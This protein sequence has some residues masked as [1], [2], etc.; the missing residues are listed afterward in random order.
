MTEHWKF[1]LWSDIVTVEMWPQYLIITEI[2][3]TSRKRQLSAYFHSEKEYA[4]SQKFKKGNGLLPYKVN[5]HPSPSYW[6]EGQVAPCWKHYGK[7]S[8]ISI[9]AK[10]R[11][12]TA[13]TFTYYIVVLWFVGLLPLLVDSEQLFHSLTTCCLFRGRQALAQSGSPGGLV[14]R[15]VAGLHPPVSDSADLGGAWA[16][17]SIRIQGQ[18]H[19]PHIVSSTGLGQRSHFFSPVSRTFVKIWDVL[20]VTAEGCECYWHLMGRTR[21]P[22]K[23]PAMHRVART[24]N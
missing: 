14:K 23:H 17:V 22:T 10:P 20:F 12:S 9:T 1:C 7:E 16:S 15:P 24:R 4:N 11:R 19:G 3:E 18:V 6:R 8:N 13:P 5:T 21:G 2:E